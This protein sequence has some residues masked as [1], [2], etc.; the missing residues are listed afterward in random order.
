MQ[1]IVIIGGGIIGMSAAYTLSQSKNYDVTVI[2]Q[3]DPG[4]ATDAAAG[5][6]CPWL[7]KRRNKVWYE[8]AKQGARYYRELMINL[9]KEVHHDIGFQQ[10][11]AMCIRDDKQLLIDL[12]EKAESRRKD[13]PEIGEITLLTHDQAKEEFPLLK[14][15]FMGLKISGGARVNGRALRNALEMA[16]VK[17]G[18]SVLHGFA[19]LCQTNGV[20]DGV[21]CHTIES[22]IPADQVIIA[23]GAWERHL[24]APLGLMTDITPQ[25]GQ[26]LHLRLN[27]KQTGV[28][29]VILPPIGQ[30]IVPF[31]HGQ[32]VIGAT[33]EKHKGF[34]LSP[35]V[36][37]IYDI[38]H[39]A[40]RFAPGLAEG[41][42]KEWRVGSRGFTSDFS[43]FIG[44]VPGYP[45]LLTAN[46]LG[47]SGL[48]TGPLVGKLLAESV[49]GLDLTMPIDNYDPAPY[50]REIKK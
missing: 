22:I 6:I 15:H 7:S 50:I 32:V 10:V 30:S 17:Q 43:P 5:I 45:N 18:A 35:T 41:E 44:R 39:Q 21:G 33:H 29:P 49:M 24:L 12:A 19:N 16:A 13:A 47:A 20:V 31:E 23:A 25:K 14:D 9:M 37:S 42:I 1:K 11:G 28:W 4:Q 36:G 26:L 38:L 40:L 48:T 3:K 8:L 2:D 34:D 46:G 27:N